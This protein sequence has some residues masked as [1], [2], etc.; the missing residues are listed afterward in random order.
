MSLSMIVSNVD[1]SGV[2]VRDHLSVSI[3]TSYHY[4]RSDRLDLEDILDF[5]CKGNDDG[6][7]LL[8]SVRRECKDLK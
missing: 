5:W 7:S 4:D 6:T 2:D 1:D 3:S 8:S